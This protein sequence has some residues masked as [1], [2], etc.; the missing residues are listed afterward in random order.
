MMTFEL[1][2]EHLDQLPELPTASSSNLTM[3]Q[4]V[5]Q[6]DDFGDDLSDEDYER[7]IEEHERQIAEEE[8][9]EAERLANSPTDE[10][11]ER[12]M[13]EY[14]DS[15]NDDEHELTDEE[16]AELEAQMDHPDKYC[17][18]L[19][20]VRTTH[21]SKEEAISNKSDACRHRNWSSHHFFFYELVEHH[22][23]GLTVRHLPPQ[24]GQEWSTRF[25][26]L[27]VDNKPQKGHQSPNVTAED[28]DAV[29][30]T[31]G[32]EATAY[33]PSTS[34]G[35]NKWH[36]FVFLT[37]PVRTKDEYDQARDKAD[38]RLRKAI[39]TLRGIKA[40]PAL[41]DP[42]VRWQSS[43]YAPYQQDKHEIVLRDWSYNGNQLNYTV[44]EAH[45]ERTITNPTP[46]L[47]TDTGED[48][49]KDTLVPLTSSKFCAWLRHEGLTTVERIDD[50][51]YDFRLSGLLPY[52]RKGA[53]KSTRQFEEGERHMRI[54]AFMLKFYAQARS[55]N[56]YMDEHGYGEHKF[57]DDDIVNSFKHYVEQAFDT[58]G[59]YDL[60]KHID[61]LKDKMLKYGR[62]SDRDYLASVAKFAS[63]RHRFR[64]RG[65]TSTTASKI[66][67]QFLTA[68]G[69]VEFDSTAYRESYLKDQRV[70]LPTLKKMASAKGLK[71]RTA[72]KS[73]GGARSGAGRKALVSWDTL[74]TK[75]QVIDGVF[76]YVGQLSSTEKNFINGQRVK[77]KKKKVG[78]QRG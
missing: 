70:S 67:D 19:Q 51:E 68:D 22:R 37:N 46:I 13:D 17:E 52:V 21:T 49:F 69:A 8:A 66:I 53:N 28:L 18:E 50:L 59:G 42:K 36:I 30:P 16:V 44:D 76:H 45:G 55:Y 10:E 31:L 57:S 23:N 71:I 63:G 65:Y 1:D 11:F 14:L 58:I 64:T 27:D 32:Y 6:D 4:P 54:S 9:E 25:L 78:N 35:K 40:L 74:A 39:A 73:K 48:Y 77:M 60:D 72:N 2:Q 62:R 56:L 26:F 75:G 5:T 43:L 61:E 38:E 33:T 47:K 7:F 20:Y 34:R 41:L 24:P 3:Q 29:L 12:M 15:L